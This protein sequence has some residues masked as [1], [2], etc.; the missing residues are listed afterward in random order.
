MDVTQNNY[1]YDITF[2]V[3][4][5][6]G[7][8]ENLAGISAI[9]YQVVDVDTFR[10]ILDG[11]CVISDAVN[12]E[13]KYTVLQ[14]DFAKAGNFSGSL[15]IQYTPSKKVNTKSFFITVNRQMASS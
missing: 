10:N 2:T 3:K 15:Q 14:G 12:G 6:D 8:A 5:A 7:T 4:K 1:G 9:K 13:C 11:A